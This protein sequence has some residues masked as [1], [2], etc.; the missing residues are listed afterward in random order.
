MFNHCFDNSQKEWRKNK[1][2]FGK[3]YFRYKCTYPKC[4]N[5]LYL[6]TT[7][8]PHFNL[9]A[10]EFDLINKENSLKYIYCEEHL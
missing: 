5:A 2:Y 6:Y 4:E 1:I 9:F 10:S 8:N 7:I 3:G